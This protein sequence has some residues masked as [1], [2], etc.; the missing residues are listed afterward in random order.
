VDPG[1]VASDDESAALAVGDPADIVSPPSAPVDMWAAYADDGLLLASV[2][3]DGDGGVGTSF[4]GLSARGQKFVF[5]TDCSS[6]MT[7]KAFTGLLRE[8]H[9]TI[10]GLP[11]RAEFAVIFFND[12]PLVRSALTLERATDGAKKGYLEWIDSVQPSG[13]TDP[14][15]ALAEALRLKPSVIFLLTDGQFESASTLN[16]IKKFNRYRRV[17]IHAI[18]LGPHADVEI[19]RQIA[20][21]NRGELKAVR[22]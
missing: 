20:T 11:E 14:S 2:G 4:Y 13:G 16:V 1:P 19:L 15:E 18:A 17:R 7:G 8:L 6:S 22:D 12:G 5:V 10:E 21:K 3:G 9:A